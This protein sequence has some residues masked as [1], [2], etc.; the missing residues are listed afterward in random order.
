MKDASMRQMTLILLLLAGCATVPPV[1]PGPLSSAQ[2]ASQPL[3]SVA[4]TSGTG[5][6]L[7][8]SKG[9]ILPGTKGGILPG[10]KGGILPGTK[11]E[12]VS[13]ASLELSVQV[14]I[15]ESFSVKQLGT[16]EI[17]TWTVSV[18]GRPAGLKL[19]STRQQGDLQELVFSLSKLDV[20]VGYPWQEVK[21]H[22]DGVLQSAGLVP[23]FTVG[24]ERV[25]QALSSESLATWMLV[26]DLQTEA[27]QTIQDS[28]T[29]WV[30]ALA[31]LP[32]TAELAKTLKEIYRQSRGKSDPLSNP[33]AEAK[34]Q[35][36][37]TKAKEKMPG[38]PPTAGPPSPRPE[39]TPKP[40]PSAKPAQTGK[41]D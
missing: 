21:F 36:A 5:Q 37:K 29:A 20:L 12:R 22:A 14:P 34:L 28:D 17:Q 9:A 27:S 3:G 18:D 38:K 40:E 24:Q 31:A 39:R 30:Q 8:G 16:S 4:G 41:P 1:P 13:L 15:S 7:P 25:E 2:P 6:I 32:E 23:A 33:Q 35:A 11:G 26:N 19:L 10:S